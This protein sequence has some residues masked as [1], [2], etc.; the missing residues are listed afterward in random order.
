MSCCPA[1]ND[2]DRLSIILN[3]LDVVGNFTG[4]VVAIT[5]GILQLHY[6]RRHRGP[7]EDAHIADICLE[8][9]LPPPQPKMSA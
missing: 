7:A 3:I 6:M 1:G 9:R 2:P 5:I 8:R 4:V